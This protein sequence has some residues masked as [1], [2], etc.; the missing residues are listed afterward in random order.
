LESQRGSIKAA[1][2]KSGGKIYR[3]GG[4]AELLGLRPTTLSSRISA[5]GIKRKRAFGS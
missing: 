4:A 2:E 5:L 1:L 3:K